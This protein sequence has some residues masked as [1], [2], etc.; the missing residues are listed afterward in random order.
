RRS[1]ALLEVQWALVRAV[2]CQVRGGVDRE[3][4]GH[5]LGVLNRDSL[6][7]AM[8][9]RTSHQVRIGL[10][11]LVQVVGIAAFAAEEGGVFGAADGF[12][13]HCRIINGD[14]PHFSHLQW[15][16]S[17]GFLKTNSSLQNPKVFSF[18]T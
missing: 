12:T 3:Y 7:G 14:R 1:V 16:G 13:N 4:P 2:R 18:L 15:I 5:A 8:R 17:S 9:M 11:G 10:P 6:Q